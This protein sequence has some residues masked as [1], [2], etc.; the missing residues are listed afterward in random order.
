MIIGNK[1][2]LKDIQLLEVT[3][4]IGNK[5]AT[6]KLICLFLVEIMIIGKDQK[7]QWEVKESMMVGEDK[8]DLL[9]EITIIG[10]IKLKNQF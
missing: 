1:K 5:L 4:T 7:D 10:K 9:E 8:K 6:F 3:M 2:F